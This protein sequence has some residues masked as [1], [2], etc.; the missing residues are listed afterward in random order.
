MGRERR[1]ARQD[2]TI[3]EGCLRAA[4]EGPF[5]SDRLF[6]TLFGL[7]RSEVAAVLQQW[8]EVQD[9]ETAYLA[10][11]NAINNLLG[12]PHRATEEDW[13]AFVPVSREELRLFFSNW[14]GRRRPDS[15]Q[16]FFDAME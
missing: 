15:A 5:F 8:P 12:Y 16:G 9:T 1:L 13:D 6:H 10:I 4:V 7:E 14:R 11:N 3:I 2:T